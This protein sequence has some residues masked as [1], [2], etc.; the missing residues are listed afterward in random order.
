MN[1]EQTNYFVKLWRQKYPER[2]K[3]HA[4]VFVAL[5]NGS[6]TKQPC[7]KCG[8]EKVEA[9]HEDYLKPLE[10]NWLCKKHHAEA[11]KARRLRE[12][13]NNP[14]PVSERDQKIISLRKQG[15]RYTE[16]ADMFNLTKQRVHQIISK[17]Y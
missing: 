13:Q 17:T 16:I 6:I 1:R 15:K 12:K 3:A 9:H 2:R 8:C 14:T 5:R 4:D 11:D 10:I 7:E